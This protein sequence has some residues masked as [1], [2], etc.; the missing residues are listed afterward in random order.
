MKLSQRLLSAALSC[1][2]ISSAAVS[3]TAFADDVLSTETVISDIND[4]TESAESKEEN[5]EAAAQAT[6]AQAEDAV[7][8]TSQNETEQ[9]TAAV[10]AVVKFAEAV[11]EPPL[12][13]FSIYNAHQGYMERLKNSEN[14]YR[15]AEG[16][17]VS[18]WQHEVDWQK[19]KNAGIDFAIIRA[20]YGKVM[21][22]K[23]P[24]FDTNVQQAQALGIDTGTYW[25]SYAT[26]VEAAQQRQKS[27]TKS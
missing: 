1:A 27:A 3:Q 14:L 21:S 8:Q 6:E 18:E 11:T 4:T 9:T 20:G 15:R 26:T 13:V 25:Y 16:I 7:T 17:D 24:Y 5:V 23:D 10:D 19:V 22:Q 12:N 2:F